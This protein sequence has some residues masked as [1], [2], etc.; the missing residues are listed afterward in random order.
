MNSAK[1]ACKRMALTIPT[2]LA[3]S[4][5]IFHTTTFFSPRQRLAL[6][7][8]EQRYVNPW[9]PDPTEDLIA[10]YHLNDTFFA[11]YIAWIREVLRGNLGYSFLYKMPVSKV[12]LNGFAATLELVLFAFPIIFLGGYKLG[13]LS[14]NRAHKRKGKED[15]VDFSIRSLSILGYSIPQFCVALLVLLVFYLCL[16]WIGPGRLGSMSQS[17]VSSLEW[18]DYT[19]LY[20]V[21]ALLNGDLK[22][23]FDALMHLV[24]PVMTLT[25]STLPIVTRITR[26]SMLEE[27]VK[28]YVL[29]AK[30]KG[31]NEKTVAKRVGRNAL[32]P[33]LTVSGILLASMLTGVIVTEHVFM[34]HGMGSMIVQ[35][36]RRLDYPLL[37]GF[38]L[39]FFLLFTIINLAVDIIYAYI[40]PRIGQ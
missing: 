20:T 22:V 25:V 8:S 1:Y 15:L 3:V 6:Y 9:G 4:L 5:I 26:S 27:L 18:T 12:I 30:A 33:V 28:P 7:L 37:V 29:A 17:I 31:L 11:Q 35:A 34:I 10:K 40:N 32:T 23:F 21:D 19:G 16:G 36:A 38:T 39:V 2:L 24:L 14:A 13:V